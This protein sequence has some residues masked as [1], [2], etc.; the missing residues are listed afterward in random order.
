V[1]VDYFKWLFPTFASS[2]SRKISA[3]TKI[4]LKDV[5]PEYRQGASPCSRNV[6]EKLHAFLI[7][8]HNRYFAFGP[9]VRI[10]LFS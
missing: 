7:L 3:S 2:N 6:E 9:L 4:S 5:S 1:L 8:Q 10:E